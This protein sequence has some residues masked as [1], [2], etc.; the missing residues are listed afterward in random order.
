M[1]TPPARL[2]SAD[3]ATRSYT[4][5][6]QTTTFPVTLAGSR[7]FGPHSR[8]S[9]A[10][11]PGA[12]AEAP[13]TAGEAGSGDRLRLTPRYFL[14]LPRITVPSKRCAVVAATVVSQGATWPTVLGPGPSLP[15]DAETKI[16]A[17]AACR[18]ARSARPKASPL[19]PTEKLMTSTPS[20]TAWSIAEMMSASLPLAEAGLDLK[21]QS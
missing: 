15:A 1:P 14:P 13:R 3:L 12:T 5:R 9:V 17:A 18:N 20:A 4:P 11:L 16:P 10:L 8:A 2:T 6:S 19:A 7:L 21:L